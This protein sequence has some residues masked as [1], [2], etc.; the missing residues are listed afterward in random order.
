[1]NPERIWSE[2]ELELVNNHFSSMNHKELL[3]MLPNRTLAGLRS[4]AYTIGLK[5]PPT[6]KNDVPNI[7]SETQ[8]AYLAGL[9]DGEGTITLELRKSRCNKKLVI[10]PL[11]QIANTDSPLLREVKKMLGIG[12]VHI[13]VHKEIRQPM[14]SYRIGSQQGVLK[15]LEQIHDYLILKKPQSELV[16]KWL[17]IHK[18]GKKITQKEI[19][20]FRE[21]KKLVN[22][23]RTPKYLSYEV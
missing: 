13:T 12:N 2:R 21:S 5:K 8:K 18:F 4:K 7:L 10:E 1:M 11:L 22:K 6:P 20:M 16:I 15:I 23:G 14:H 19:E 3:E 17:K 9:I